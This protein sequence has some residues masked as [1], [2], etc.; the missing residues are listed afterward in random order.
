VT[1]NEGTDVTATLAQ[2][3]TLRVRVR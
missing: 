1:V 2:P 3:L